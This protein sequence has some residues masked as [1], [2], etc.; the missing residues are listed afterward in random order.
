MADK[1]SG[2]A[3]YFIIGAVVV[4]TLAVAFFMMQESNE[5]D[6]AIDVNEDGIEVETN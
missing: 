2:N 5:P 3:L 1:P 4:A 6:F